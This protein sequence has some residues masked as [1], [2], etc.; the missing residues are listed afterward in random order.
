MDDL[1]GDMY[2]SGGC[3]V[4]QVIEMLC[5]RNHFQAAKQRNGALRI[6]DG[7]QF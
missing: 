3:S 4:V 5:A 2:Y 6:P 1:H 7:T